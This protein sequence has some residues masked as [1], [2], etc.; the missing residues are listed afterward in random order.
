MRIRGKFLC[1][2]VVASAMCALVA[3]GF[4][5]GATSSES[6]QLEVYVKT[7]Q[8]LKLERSLAGARL[9]AED[10]AFF[11]GI[12][13]NRKNRTGESIRLLAPIEGK[14][15]AA[16]ASWREK[17]T[18]N[19]LGDDYNKVFEYAK[20]E[21]VFS[22]MLERYGESLSA[23]ERRNIGERQEEMH[24]LRGAPV[25]TAEQNAPAI[26]PATADALGLIEVPVEAGG[27][28]ESWVIDTGANTCVV[29]ESTAQRIG[30][31][32]LE[33]TAT[34]DDIGGLPVAYRVGVLRELKIGNSVLHNVELPVTA[35]KSLFIGG[36]QIQGIIGFPAQAALGRITFYADGR[37]EIRSEESNAA[38]SELFMEWQT[39]VVAAK[40]G[41]ASGLFTLD[42]GNTGSMLNENYYQAVKAT[43]PREKSGTEPIIG[44]GGT[45]PI[46]SVT[47]TNLLVVIG[48]E[49][50][51]LKSVPVLTAG[52]DSG[53]D[54]FFGNLGQGVFG[55]LRSY[56][57]DFEKMKFSATK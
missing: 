2:T 24:L 47:L 22:A 43:L 32:L 10:G 50:I 45:R 44:A 16:P 15:A 25:Q 31:Q 38:A 17:E 19:T 14:L 26:L 23:R 34:T 1:G 56:T 28:K 33:G 5:M 29:T 9:S 42:T 30:L 52:T 48:E 3:A 27:K 55:A 46:P 36:Y 7:K 53:L 6:A 51:R 18:L 13:D 8:Y 40:A 11:Q 57:I 49:R 21:R 37:V 20:A 41:E 4:V 12:Q 54:D 39:P 35:D